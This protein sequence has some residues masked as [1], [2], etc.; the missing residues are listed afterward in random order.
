MAR[1]LP[2]LLE[3][4]PSRETRPFA[5][6]PKKSARRAKRKEKRCV[7]KIFMLENFLFSFPT[8]KK[9]FLSVKSTERGR[10][11]ISL[12]LSRSDRSARDFEICAQKESLFFLLSPRRGERERGASLSFS[13][14][15]FSSQ[16]KERREGEREREHWKRRCGGA[17]G[18][19][20]LEIFSFF[21]VVWSLF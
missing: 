1:K 21:L 7:D 13:S 17:E 15:S 9:F 19:E 18:K 5:R 16:R 8:G 11:V 2:R 14:S 6:R 3:S 20:R 4:K 10:G 12:S